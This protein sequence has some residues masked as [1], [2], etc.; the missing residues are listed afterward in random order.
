LFWNARLDKAF[1]TGHGERLPDGFFCQN[2]DQIFENLKPSVQ[3]LFS[4]ASRLVRVSKET[5]RSVNCE[6]LGWR[7][8]MLLRRI[9]HDVSQEK[10]LMYIREQKKE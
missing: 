7:L 10:L 8:P 5:M 2:G 9:S 4:I 1:F 6:N 3:E